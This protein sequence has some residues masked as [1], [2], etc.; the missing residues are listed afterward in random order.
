MIENFNINISDKL[1]KDFTPKFYKEKVLENN[2][3]EDF[4]PEFDKDSVLETNLREDLTP[5]FEK[6]ERLENGILPNKEEGLRREKEV[7]EDLKEKYPERD[8]YKIES[9]VYLRD[10]DGDIVKDK[11]TGES[12][13]IDY[14]VIKNNKVVDSIEVTSKTADKTEQSSKEERI[15]ENGGN[16]IKDSDENLIEIPYSIKTRIERRD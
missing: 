12:R 10:K 7:L 4:N 11:E 16:Y 2:I 5:N 6:Y 3:E 8:G 13:R 15:R 1:S 9:E 14:V